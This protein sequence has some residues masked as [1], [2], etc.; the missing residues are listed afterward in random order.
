VK[1][2]YCEVCGDIIAPYRQAY[3]VRWCDCRRHAVWWVDPAQGVLRAHD[4][5]G[6]I[7]NCVCTGWPFEAKAYVLGITNLFLSG[8]DVPQTPEYMQQ[9]ID[10]HDDYYLFKRRNQVI[11]RL[12]PGESG[13]TRWAALP[14]Q[15]Q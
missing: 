12:R 4:S 15:T 1:L 5:R 2:L 10:A 6:R 7:D 3:Q 13:D 9:I 8:P 14:E 11:V